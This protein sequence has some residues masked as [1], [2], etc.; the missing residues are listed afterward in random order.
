MSDWKPNIFDFLDYR[1]FLR[2]YYEAAKA[3]TSAFSY[4]YFARK[5]GLSSPSFLRHVMRGERNIGDTVEN[6]AKAL[7]LNAEETQFFR[8]LID[9]DQAETDRERNRAFEKLAASRRFRTA[10]RIDQAMFD[11][12]SHW[13]YPAIREMVARPDFDEDPAWIAGQL[14][15]NIEPEQAETALEVLLDLGLVVREDSGTLVRGEASVTTEHE[16][17]SLAIANYHR[18]MLERAGESIEIIPRE[19]RDLAA[20]TVCISPETI[21]ELKE[22]VHAF[23]ELVFELCDSDEEPQVVFQINTQLF[24]LSSLPDDVS[25]DD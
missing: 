6:F 25:G 5:A 23:R 14:T 15:P 3:N 24:P 11:Y 4:R 8:L 16:V 9:F 13:Y 12:L 22:R 19:Y 2:A 17:R 18:Q 20:M 21:G 7:E 1:A 10:R